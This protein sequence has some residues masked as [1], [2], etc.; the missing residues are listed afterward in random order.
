MSFYQPPPKSIEELMQRANTL[1]GRT[2]GEIAE[3]LSLDV[4]ADLKTQKG[5]QG[6]FIEAVLGADSGNL[7]Q[8]DFNHLGIELKTL[9]IGFN[10]RVLESTYVCVL[11]LNQPALALWQ[12]S[13]VYKKLKHILWVPIAKTPDLSV[14]EYCVA[15]P[16]LWQAPDSILTILQQD[17]EEAMALVS[18]GKIDKLNARN[19]EFLQVR[20][21]AAHS[22]VLTEAT[23]RE[24]QSI[25]TLPRG[26]YLRPS[27]TQRLL[28]S[29]LKLS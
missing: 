6:Q 3:R 8:P 11:N 18:T 27:L 16:F 25:Q 14:M 2:I 23:D 12:E 1:A 4:P 20:P 29:H 5:W 24:G 17:W 19:G 9:P 10:G 22:R 13:P 21:K 28:E 26:F 15:T 7:S